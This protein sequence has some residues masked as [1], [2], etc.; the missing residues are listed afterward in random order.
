MVSASLAWTTILSSSGLMF[1][2]SMTS[3]SQGVVLRM[4][5]GFN[6]LG[7]SRRRGCRNVL[8]AAVWLALY[9]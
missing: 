3:S 5:I 8:V 9:P 2:T 4:V 6:G 7:T 1:A